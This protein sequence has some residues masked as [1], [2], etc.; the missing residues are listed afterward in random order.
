M[1]NYCPECG[2]LLK[3]RLFWLP[4]AYIILVLVLMIAAFIFGAA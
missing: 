2:K 4:V 1:A 3:S